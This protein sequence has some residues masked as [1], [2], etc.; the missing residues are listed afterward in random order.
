MFGFYTR[1]CFDPQTSMCLKYYDGENIA[2]KKNIYK[3][4]QK[5]R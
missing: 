2:M 4:T 5:I 1:E 3:H